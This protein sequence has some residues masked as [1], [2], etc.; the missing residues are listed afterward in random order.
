M[1]V[2][3]LTKGYDRPGGVGPGRC[4][5][6]RFTTMP[7]IAECPFCRGKV[8]VP[9][10]SEGMSLSCPRCADSFTLARMEYPP[11]VTAEK[12]RP[13]PAAAEA[14]AAVL[15]AVHEE[16]KPEPGAPATVKPSAETWRRPRVFPFEL[17][18]GVALV[19][20]GAGVAFAP[21]PGFQA[22]SISLGGCA[23]AAG[24]AGWIVA[25]KP[26]RGGRLR[27]ALAFALGGAV[28]IVTILWPGFLGGGPPLGDNTPRPL[29]RDVPALKVVEP[30]GAASVLDSRALLLRS[31]SLRVQFL[32]VTTGPVRFVGREAADDSER[33]V[34]VALRIW[35]GNPDRALRYSGWGRPVAGD[36]TCAAVL[37]DGNGKTYALRE[38][39]ANRQVVGQVRDTTL[40]PLGQTDDVLVFEIP[41]AGVE[42]VALELPL[43]AVGGSGILQAGISLSATTA[44]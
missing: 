35:N 1:L 9:D 33:G 10:E 4:A 7:F 2:K 38:Y 20:A 21:L 28:L 12:L 13:P 31:G 30:M 6:L 15:T 23:M 39:S 3:A 27:P 37:R 36:Q 19:F 25:S 17:I 5:R 44:R 24:L 40:P 29:G 42:A 16:E 18:G 11:V 26:E 14:A 8:R 43:A 34:Q 32:R 22:V 41:P